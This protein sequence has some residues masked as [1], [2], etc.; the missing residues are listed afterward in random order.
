M[1]FRL[2]MFFILL[3]HCV[4]LLILLC[5]AVIQKSLNVSKFS[6]TFCHYWMPCLCRTVVYIYIYIY[7][8]SVNWLQLKEQMK[9]PRSFWNVILCILK[10]CRWWS[11]DKSCAGA[12]DKCCK[13][14]Q[15]W[16]YGWLW[17]IW[18]IGCS[19]AVIS[20]TT[21][22]LGEVFVP[23]RR[24]DSAMYL[25]QPAELHVLNNWTAEWL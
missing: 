3:F 8:D 10:R 7:I 21:Q 19:F 14:I 12:I 5:I 11:G 18:L 20:N 25:R 2:L 22:V 23:R 6:A 15:I 1:F 24:A 9:E 4:V 13:I 17:V 16:L